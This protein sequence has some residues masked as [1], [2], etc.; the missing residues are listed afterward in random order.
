[1]SE[2]GKTAEKIRLHE[3][4]RNREPYDLKA[5]AAAVPALSDYIKPNKYGA[6]SVDF[7]QPAAVKL[8][9]KALLKHYYGIENWD[10]PDENLCPPVPGRADYLHY[11]ADLLAQSNFG[12][13]PPPSKITVLDIGTG[14]SCIY[15]VLGVAEYGWNFIAADINAKSVESAEQIVAVNSQLAECV[16][17][18]LQPDETKIFKNIISAGERVDFSMCNPPFHASTEEAANGTRRKT[19]N[20]FGKHA[21]RPAL[22]FSG[23]S[24]ELVCPGGELGFIKKMISESVEFG[25][26]IYWFSTLVS[27]QS[28]LK[29][30]YKTLTDHEV[31]S[32]KTIPMGTGNKVSRIICWSF[33]DKKEQQ[34]WRAAHWKK[35]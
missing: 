17:C 22:N 7:T 5:L 31:M 32:V 4:N 18:M 1:M 11:M 28:N 34:E 23:I 10:F 3:R 19:N 29:S 30:I 8:L 24:K 6:L 16:R 15:P 12:V 27:K 14:A 9:N 13:V 21:K 26:N 25:K 20:L 35:A 2:P 33:L